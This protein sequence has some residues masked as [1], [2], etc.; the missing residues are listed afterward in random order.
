MCNFI[1]IHV[2]RR[3]NSR[4]WN[5]WIPLEDREQQL[6]MGASSWMPSCFFS[7]SEAGFLARLPKGYCKGVAPNTSTAKRIRSEIPQP[8]SQ[9]NNDCTTGPVI[10]DRLPMITYMIIYIWLPQTSTNITVRVVGPFSEAWDELRLWS[11]VV[12]H[13]RTNGAYSAQNERPW[14]APLWLLSCWSWSWWKWSITEEPR[15]ICSMI[16][17]FA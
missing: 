4:V 17:G 8:S 15:S 1:C 10:S 12:H 9:S 13:Q 16:H 7:S 11:I 2:P 6:S 3:A 14:R 5:T